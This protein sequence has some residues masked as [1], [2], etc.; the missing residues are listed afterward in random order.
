MCAAVE[1]NAN[2]DGSDEQRYKH[3]DGV[4][5]NHRRRDTNEMYMG[6]STHRSWSLK[7]R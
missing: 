6:H 5:E 1:N 4:M 2:A 3:S 7:R